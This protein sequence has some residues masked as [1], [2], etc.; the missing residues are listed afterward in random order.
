MDEM[1]IP[2]SL[3]PTRLM[4]FS[5]LSPSSVSSCTGFREELIL[6]KEEREGRKGLHTEIHVF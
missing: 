6:E 2:L 5:R 1:K 4:S 3:P